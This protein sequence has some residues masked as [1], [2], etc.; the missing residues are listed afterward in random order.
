M[1]EFFF[2]PPGKKYKSTVM[3]PHDMFCKSLELMVNESLDYLWS[4]DKTDYN[5]K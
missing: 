3:C 2:P 5:V 4:R 1:N